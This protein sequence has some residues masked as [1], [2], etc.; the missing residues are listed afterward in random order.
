MNRALKIAQDLLEKGE[1]VAVP[2]ETVYGLAANAFDAIAV[3]KIFQ[4]KERPLFNP[5]IVHIKSIDYLNT[6]AQNIPDLAYKLA[7]IFWP[8]PLTLVLEK[9]ACIP[10]VVTAGKNTVGVRVPSHPLILELLTALNFPLAA[11]SANPFGYISPTQASHVQD[12]LGAKI[13]YILDGGNCQ[14]GIES[15]IIGFKN[16]KAILY[17]VGAISKETIEN[18]IGKIDEKTASKASPEAPGM[19]SKHYSPKT[20]FIVSENIQSEIDKNSTAKIGL[21]LLK[22]NEKW[23]AYPQKILSESG[24]MFEAAQNLYAKM[25]ELDEMQLDCI[26]AEQMP[27]NNLGYSINDR[28]FRAQK[29]DFEF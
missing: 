15:T 17:R 21:L 7:A 23:T 9:K 14:R 16:N 29:T 28:L 5:L 22:F 10:D 6:V 18:E 13:P 12:Q 19:L 26:I 25:H 27:N 24:D 8:G 11:P 4:I 3:Q 2:T 20:K 1:V